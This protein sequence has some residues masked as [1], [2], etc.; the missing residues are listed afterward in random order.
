MS[1]RIS[2]RINF[3]LLNKD[4]DANIVATATEI[5]SYFDDNGNQIK[6]DHLAGVTWN[7]RDNILHYAQEKQQHKTISCQY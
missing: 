1:S 3:V 2:K 6:R 7:F 4:G 5:A